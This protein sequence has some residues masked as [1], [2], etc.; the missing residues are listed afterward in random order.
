MKS[1]SL[2]LSPKSP[3]YFQYFF[4]VESKASSPWSTQSQMKPPWSPGWRSMAAQ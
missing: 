2:G 4:P 3:P 1:R